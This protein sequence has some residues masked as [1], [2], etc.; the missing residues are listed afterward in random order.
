MGC[1]SFFFPIPL[2]VS[3]FLHIFGGSLSGKPLLTH[4]LSMAKSRVS[5]NPLYTGGA[6]GYSFYVRSGEQ[7][8]RQRR[9]NSNY[10]ESASRSYAQMI[11]R[12]KWGNLVNIFKCIKSWQPKAYDS[13]AV[14][15][16]DYNMF[17]KLNINRATV[18]TSK[19][20]N[21]QGM[22]VW[23][24]YQ[25]SN[26]SLPAINYTLDSSSHLYVTDI[27]VTSAITPAMTVGE[28][29][30][31]LIAN[32]PR[33]KAGDNLA[34]IIVKNHQYI[35]VEYPY[36]YSEY[37][38]ITLDVTSTKT[39]NEVAVL[40]ALLTENA[41]DKLC[42]SYPA[43]EGGSGPV[44]QG[45][46]IIHT[47][48]VN[49]TLQVSS[50]SVLMASDSF[51]QQYSGETWYQ[52]CIDSYGIDTE[53]PLDP[54]FSEGVISK[55]TAN[56]AIVANAATLSGSQ[57]I[58][59]YGSSLYGQGYRF[60]HNGVDYTPLSS[61][62]E[63]DE[64]TLTAN[65]SYV[66]YVGSQVFMSFTVTGIVE[67]SYLSGYVAAYLTDDNHTVTPSTS[68]STED[69]CLNYPKKVTQ[70]LP[71]ISVDVFYNQGWTFDEDV[72]ECVGGSIISVNDHA[73]EAHFNA[74]IQP[75][76]ADSIVTLAVDQFIVIVGNYSD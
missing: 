48:K 25:V 66:I 42:V 32:N 6:G 36:A 64:F 69:G 53:V 45:I 55:V 57:S 65:G 4:Q 27:N 41:Q 74:V 60:V 23:E 14:G 31:E 71:Y 73:S 59:V 22:A 54:N 62:D 16:T 18:G 7:V 50:Q 40:G 19:Q 21:E 10:G 72:L 61:T 56:G 38:E 46:A 67:P 76:S 13:K 29:A 68:M 12:I 15:V 37:Y 44:I 63:Y 26:G 47:R 49:G 28:F 34:F 5:I 43:S 30:A 52:H 35:G 17:M 33:F 24:A 2:E 8:V 11:R 3:R 70:S 39:L 75:A 9:N 20:A 1:D 51:I 58:R